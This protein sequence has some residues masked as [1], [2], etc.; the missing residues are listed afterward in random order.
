[1]PIDLSRFIKM[2]GLIVLKVDEKST[3]ILGLKTRNF[4]KLKVTV[5][6]QTL[7]FKITYFLKNIVAYLQ[8]AG[9]DQPYCNQV[10]SS[11][12]APPK[13]ARRRHIGVS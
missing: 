7:K 5:T 1:M 2:D 13:L 4:V 10:R 11:N 12:N 3:F 9:L 6:E 8:G